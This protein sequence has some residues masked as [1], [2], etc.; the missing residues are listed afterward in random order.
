MISFVQGKGKSVITT[1]IS[2]TGAC[3]L[4]CDYCSVSQRKKH[5]K[6][7]VVTI[8][9]YIHQLVERGLKAIIFTGGGEPTIYSEWNYMIEY[10]KKTS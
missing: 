6:L 1:H 3:N 4:N 8:L 2:P 10:L 7:D 9:H 5:E